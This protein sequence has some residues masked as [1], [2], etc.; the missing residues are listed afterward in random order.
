MGRDSNNT[1]RPV[2]L[3]VLRGNARPIPSER[4]WE[5]R[6]SRQQRTSE[7]KAP[8]VAL[9]A[10]ISWLSMV[11]F[12]EDVDPCTLGLSAELLERVRADLL[13][14]SERDTLET[15]WRCLELLRRIEVSE[16]LEDLDV[17]DSK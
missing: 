12:V 5:E 4:D 9:L 17:S 1:K 3:H 6:R 15:Y 2:L 14:L 16:K 11:C 8:S 10:D 13:V 7:P